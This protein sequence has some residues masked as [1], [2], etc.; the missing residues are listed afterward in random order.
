MPDATGWQGIFVAAGTPP[1]IVARLQAEIARALNLPDIKEN[2]IATGGEVGG[3][4][5]AEFA[6]FVRADR[7]NFGKAVEQLKILPE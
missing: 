7:M 5:S 1:A 2:I 3:N 4:S 6:A